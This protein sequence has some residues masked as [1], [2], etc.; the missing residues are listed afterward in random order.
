MKIAFKNPMIRSRETL[1]GAMNLNHF[2]DEAIDQNLLSFVRTEREVL[3]N[4][5]HHLREAERRRLFCKRGFASLFEYATK[6]L[7]YS[8]DEAIRRISAMRLLRELPQ[9]EEKIES[10]ALKLTQLAKAQTLFRQETKA[11]LGR[12][13]T[14]K[15]DFLTKIQSC[16]KRELEKIIEVEGRIQLFVKSSKVA[17]EQFSTEVQNKLQRLM[18]VLAHSNP[19]IDVD[20][21]VAKLADLGLEKWDPIK[22]AERFEKR[23][24]GTSLNSASTFPSAIS[25]A[26]PSTS[27]PNK[28]D[29]LVPVPGKVERLSEIKEQDRA[30]RH[31]P[32]AI[33]HAVYLR[34]KGK[35]TN[36]GS[37]RAIEVDHIIPF[38]KGGLSE[39]ENLRLLCRSCN[40]HHAIGT[41][42]IS[43]MM[44]YF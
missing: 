25:S 22:K 28:R 21:L 34:D 39:P 44:N 10:G 26:L 2:N 32:S 29:A 35:C 7:G 31:I 37:T 18:D 41:Y 8:E 20:T 27:L 30:K 12:T 19:G 38:A 33:R 13:S 1:G 43:K 40:Q 11:N 36:C 16:T 17:L 15:L 3:T 14:E 23:K 4:I 24:A 6:R 5:L 42:G 9:I